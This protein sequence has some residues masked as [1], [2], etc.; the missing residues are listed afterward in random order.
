[1]KTLWSASWW[2][3]YLPSSYLNRCITEAEKLEEPISDIQLAS[4]YYSARGKHHTALFMVWEWITLFLPLLHLL[5]VHY[6]QEKAALHAQLAWNY[7]NT[8]PSARLSSGAWDVIG[9]I[10]MEPLESIGKECLHRAA[11]VAREEDRPPHE[12]GLPLARLALVASRRQGLSWEQRTEISELL[13]EVHTKVLGKET[14]YP[15]QT[16]RV[17]LLVAECYRNLHNFEEARRAAEYGLS[18]ATTSGA[19]TQKSR[20]RILLLKIRVFDF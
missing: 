2:S 16:S 18:L 19:T 9:T 15:E 13:G 4:I 10:L 8:H 7:I 11:K 20:L 12:L 17:C 3:L 1:L 6:Y 5:S 14:E